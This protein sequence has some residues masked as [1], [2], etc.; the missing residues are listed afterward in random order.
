[1]GE[2]IAAVGAPRG[3]R[4]LGFDAAD[5]EQMAASAERQKRLMA[6]APVPLTREE[7]AEAL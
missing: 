2:L 4:E 5:V 1:M 7:L 6:G 3:L